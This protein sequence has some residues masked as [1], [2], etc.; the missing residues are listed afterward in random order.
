MKVFRTW[1]LERDDDGF[2]LAAWIEL[3]PWPDLHEG[4]DFAVMY[5]PEILKQILPDVSIDTSPDD[6]WLAT[7]R[8]TGRQIVIGPVVA[9]YPKTGPPDLLWREWGS[10]C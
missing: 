2:H 1:Y 10:R 3:S 7:D 6:W 4:A 8:E 5:L 9:A